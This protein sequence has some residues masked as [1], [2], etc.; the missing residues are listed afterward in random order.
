MNANF[1]ASSVVI[2]VAIAVV[3]AGSFTWPE[4]F[5]RLRIST[6][7]V[8]TLVF[9]MCCSMRAQANDSEH[10]HGACVHKWVG[11]KCASLSL[12]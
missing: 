9:G 4:Q 3:V 12:C 7:I 11:T 2:L 1:F 10:E 8:Y 5:S 6:C